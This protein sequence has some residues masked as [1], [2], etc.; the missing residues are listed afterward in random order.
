[1]NTDTVRA[2]AKR[3]ES[4]QIGRLVGLAYLLNLASW[5][6]G[7]LILGGSVFLAEGYEGEHWLAPLHGE[8]FQVSAVVGWYSLLHGLSAFLTLPCLPFVA[9]LLFYEWLQVER[10]GRRYGF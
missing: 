7:Y 1:M 9:V 2:Y 8:E 3:R 10:L 4:L 5:W 6:L